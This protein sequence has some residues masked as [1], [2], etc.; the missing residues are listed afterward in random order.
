MNFKKE[1]LIRHGGLCH[2]PDTLKAKV[3]RLW[4]VWDKLELQS[5]IPSEDKNN[6]TIFNNNNNKDNTVWIPLKMKI[7]LKVILIYSILF[8]KYRS[9]ITILIINCFGLAFVFCFCK[10]RSNLICRLGWPHANS[11]LSGWLCHAVKSVCYPFQLSCQPFEKENNLYKSC[12]AAS[13]P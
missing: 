1:Y 2:C 7:D 8:K 3:E 9:I 10:A 6:P 5:E 4:W 13:L 11:D 12:S